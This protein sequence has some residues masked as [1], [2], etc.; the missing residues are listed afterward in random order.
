MRRSV[1]YARAA[2]AI[3]LLGSALF[4]QAPSAQLNFAEASVEVGQPVRATLTVEHAAGERPK[5]DALGLDESWLVLDAQPGAT[6]ADP[7][8]P[9]RAHTR[10]ELELASLEP[11]QRTIASLPLPGGE[12]KLPVS[13]AAL[14]VRGVLGADEDAPR[15][16]KGLREIESVEP[17]SA[18]WPLVGA[19]LGALVLA[20]AGLFLWWRRRSRFAP[21]AAP[22]PSVRLAVLEARPLDTPDDVQAAHFA[23]T[24]LLRESADLAAGRDRSGLTDEEWSSA[25]R[26]EFTAAGLSAAEQQSLAALLERAATVKYGSERPTHWATREALASA[27]SLAARLESIDPALRTP[28]EVAA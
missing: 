14:N 8:S 19:A 22:A 28:R 3:C 13:G 20:A 2:F 9:G 5:L 6:I 16:L 10:W 7:A 21:Q 25:A 26:A 12:Q 23:L 15:A 24:R 4:A 11:G 27:R 17:R 1:R 18:V